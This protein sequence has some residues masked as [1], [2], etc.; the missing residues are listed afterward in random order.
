MLEHFEALVFSDRVV[1]TKHIFGLCVLSSI[2]CSVTVPI[3]ALPSSMLA[4]HHPLF[5]DLLFLA[6]SRKTVGIVHSKLLR[7]FQHSFNDSI[8]KQICFPN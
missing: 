2:S 4:T 8:R 1:E 5:Y 3:V 7:L 6:L